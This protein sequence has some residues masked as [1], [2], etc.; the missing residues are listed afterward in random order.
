MNV[1]YGSTGCPPCDDC[2]PGITPRRWTLDVTRYPLF[3]VKARLAG[4]QRKRCGRLDHDDR[5]L[6]H[7]ASVMML[8]GGGRS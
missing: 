1:G 5:G 2:I 3:E 7:G 8:Y 4:I 6:E